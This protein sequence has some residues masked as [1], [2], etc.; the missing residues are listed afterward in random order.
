MAVEVTK[1]SNVG[2]AGLEGS[3]RLVAPQ[4]ADHATLMAV[5]A[6]LEKETAQLLCMN[7]RT[8]WRGGGPGPPPEIQ[9]PPG[10][11]G[12]GARPPPPRRGPAE[13]GPPATPLPPG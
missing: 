5:K 10:A 9:N 13:G 12:E 4:K 1:L 2:R 6:R 11:R 8:S 3:L 7:C